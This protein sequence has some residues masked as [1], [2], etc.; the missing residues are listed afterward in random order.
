MKR[1][2]TWKLSNMLLNNQEANDKIKKKIKEY[3]KTNKMETQVQNLWDAIAA[4][5]ERCIAKQIVHKKQEKSRI[6]NLIT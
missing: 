6:N 3:L 2:N 1:T 4:L 5:R